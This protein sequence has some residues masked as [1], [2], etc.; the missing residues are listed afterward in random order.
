MKRIRFIIL[1]WVLAASPFGTLCAEGGDVIFAENFDSLKN[2]KPLTFEKVP[3]QSR[4]AVIPDPSGEMMLKLESEGGASALISKK[5]FS[6]KNAKFISWS[7]R[8]EE[9][10]PEADPRR[11]SGDDYAIRVYLIFQYNPERASFFKGLKYKSLKTFY[12]EYPPDSSLNY[13]WSGGNLEGKSFESPY[14]DRSRI[15]VLRSEREPQSSWS[16]EEVD[17]RSD[18]I[19]QFGEEPPET[20]QLGIMTDSDNTEGSTRAYLRTLLVSRTR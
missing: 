3:K 14:T 19:E 8:V 12:G 4:Y 10:P 17:L 1:F 15:I 18:Y 16:T 20:F 13:V 7:W 9:F 5:T 6:V 2:W 11:K